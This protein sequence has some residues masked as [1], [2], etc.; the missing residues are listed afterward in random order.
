MAVEDAVVLPRVL[1][2]VDR[3]DIPAAL[4]RYEAA[5]KERTAKIQIGSRGNNWPREGGNADWVYGSDAWNVPL[6]A[7]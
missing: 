4:G 3:D 7:T 1:D 5:R 6:A 2:G